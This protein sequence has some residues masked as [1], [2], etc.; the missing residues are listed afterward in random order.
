[1]NVS[2]ERK[3][4]YDKNKDMG[5]KERNKETASAPPEGRN[6]TTRSVAK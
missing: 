6:E 3:I 2:D 1:V 5:S 4:N